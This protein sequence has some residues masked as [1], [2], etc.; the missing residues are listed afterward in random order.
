VD[1]YE[2]DGQLETMHQQKV[3]LE[4]QVA[5]LQQTVKT[6]GLERDQASQQYQQYVQQLNG[7]LHSLASKVLTYMF[8]NIIIIIIIIIIHLFVYESFMSIKIKIL[9][10]C[11]SLSSIYQVESL[12]SE[13]EQLVTREQGL[14][15]HISDLE[16][17]LQ[18]LQQDQ[19]RRDSSPKQLK[20]SSMVQELEA[21]LELAE[22]KKLAVVE[23]LDCQVMTRQSRAFIS[24]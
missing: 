6:V 1:S 24:A 22:S 19:N 2:I 7:Q 3:S 9:E 16:K 5:D 15:R 11:S 18:Q 21:K 20:D 14:V 4:K 13:N 23:K 17:Q 8:V 12:S 10:I